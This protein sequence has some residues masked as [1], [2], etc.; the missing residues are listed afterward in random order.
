[1]SLDKEIEHDKEKRKNYYEH[2]LL[3]ALVDHMVV[4]NGVKVIGCINS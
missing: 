3:I 2:K 4:A 1:M